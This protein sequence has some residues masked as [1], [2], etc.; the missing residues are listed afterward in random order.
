M[1]AYSVCV[2]TRCYIDL[3]EAV[4]VSFCFWECCDCHAGCGQHVRTEWGILKE[5]P[6]FGG[7][8]GPGA[9]AEGGGQGVPGVPGARG[10]LRVNRE[11]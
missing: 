9:G 11:Q 5:T 10:V 2:V 3:A 7:A 4:A 8:G 6:P 1:H